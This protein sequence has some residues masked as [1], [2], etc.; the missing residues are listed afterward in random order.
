MLM[1]NK[2]HDIMVHIHKKI[3]LV[4][5]RVSQKKLIMNSLS[6]YLCNVKS[7]K[8]LDAP[9]ISRSGRDC[10]QCQGFSN[11]KIENVRL[12]IVND[13]YGDLADEIIGEILEVAAGGEDA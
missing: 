11:F 13:G 12:S 1:Q 3:T 7:C 2:I 5:A 8:P 6:Y 4:A 9:S 10:Q